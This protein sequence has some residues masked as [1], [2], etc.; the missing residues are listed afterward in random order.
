MNKVYLICGKICSGKTTYAKKLKNDKIAVILSADEIM[1]ALFGQHLGEKHEE[2]DIKTQKYLFDKSVEIISSGINVILD[3]GFWT[4]EIR[5]NTTKFY[6]DKGINI[7]QHYI[8]VSDNIWYKNIKK[9]NDSINNGQD[10]SYYIDENIITKFLNKFEMPKSNEIDVWL[11][12]NWS[13]EKL[14]NVSL[15]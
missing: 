3:W 12:N 11:K 8:D 5:K 4:H 15:I 13:Q 10:D 7:E 2:I 6:N 1:L 14:I 9:R